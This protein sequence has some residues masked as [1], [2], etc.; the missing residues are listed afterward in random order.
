MKRSVIFAAPDVLYGTIKQGGSTPL[1]FA[2]FD[3]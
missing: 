1:I 3:E 2:D